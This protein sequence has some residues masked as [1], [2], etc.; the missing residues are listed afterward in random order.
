MEKI[1]TEIATLFQKIQDVSKEYADIKDIFLDD[2]NMELVED[3]VSVI[4][5]LNNSRKALLLIK[6]KYFLRGLNYEN[7]EKESINKLIAYVDTQEKAEFIT[8]SFDKIISSN[9]KLSCCIMGLL[10]N[11]MT[12]RKCNI[13]QEELMILQVLPM[14]NDFDIKNFFYL[15]NIVAKRKGKYHNIVTSDIE[16]CAKK[17]NTVKKNIYLT[18]GVLEKYGL[19]DKEADVSLDLDEDN[20]DMS[21]VDYDEDVFF[22][23]LSEKLYGYIQVLFL[24]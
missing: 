17:C 7:V 3:S 16:C 2:N 24:K 1:S 11:D 21:S 22:N 23:S 15:Y 9:S 4:K 10:L 19:V 12:K 5:F 6:F 20:F 18:I 14:L 8:N 13:T